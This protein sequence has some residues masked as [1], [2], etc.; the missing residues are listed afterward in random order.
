MGSN[1]NTLVTRC[2]NAQHPCKHVRYISTYIYHKNQPIHGGKYTNRPMDSVWVGPGISV[3][4][5][6]TVVTVEVSPLRMRF[7]RSQMSTFPV[8]GGG[9]D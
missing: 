2:L 1:I 3:F 4:S 6:S 8:W 5:K 7:A 9:M